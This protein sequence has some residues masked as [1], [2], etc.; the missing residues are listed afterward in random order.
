M[1]DL[2]W[3]KVAESGPASRMLA[4]LAYI[5]GLSVEELQQHLQSGGESGEIAVMSRSSR[6]ALAFKIFVTS[7][8]KTVIGE[9]RFLQWLSFLESELVHYPVPSNRAATAA[10]CIESS[11]G[12]QNFLSGGQERGPEDVYVASYLASRATLL[13]GEHPQL[14][15]WIQRSLQNLPFT[16]N[17]FPLEANSQISQKPVK[18]KKKKDQ[19][20]GGTSTRKEDGKRAPGKGRHATTD[21]E[22]DRPKQKLRILC[23][24]GYRQSADTFKVKLGSFRKMTGKLADF[25]FI[26]APNRVKGEEDDYGWWFS[27]EN[28]TYDAHQVSRCCDGYAESLAL[29]EEALRTEGPFHGVLA[30]SQ[31]AA[32][33]GLLCLLQERDRLSS[34]FSFCI[35]VAGFI[36]RCT[37]HTDLFESLAAEGKK[38][39]LP[40]LHVF[41]SSDKVIEG[42]MSEELLNHFNNSKVLRHEG[43]HF[44]PTAGPA[45]QHWIDFL[46]DMQQLCFTPRD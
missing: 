46:Q 17:S 21:K 15:D 25:T 14:V 42:S 39:N 37:D 6:M 33:G 29:V 8:N 10:R 7:S 30:F 38:V 35:L 9:V 3:R 31:G 27:Q 28:S 23:L 44:V 22:A 5:C 19:S 45:K 26:T 40:T 1:S 34:S 41:G 36:S 43:G 12:D 24:H 13:G 2:E 18:S 32:L 4:N 16:H 20:P 11:L